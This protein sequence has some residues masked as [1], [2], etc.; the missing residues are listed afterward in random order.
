MLENILPNNWWGE[1]V[2]ILFYGKSTNFFIWG[3]F[4]TTM[5]HTKRR[6]TGANHFAC[7]LPYHLVYDSIWFWDKS[8]DI[9][10]HSFDTSEGGVDR[11]P[12]I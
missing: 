9:D 8:I 6:K 5:L 11:Y 4:T 7:T 12:D 2:Q 10:H 1:I 3:I